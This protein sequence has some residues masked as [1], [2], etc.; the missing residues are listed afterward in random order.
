MYL[1][2]V[3]MMLANVLPSQNRVHG[4]FQLLLHTYQGLQWTLVSHKTGLAS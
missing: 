1:L 4:G 2:E 3:C